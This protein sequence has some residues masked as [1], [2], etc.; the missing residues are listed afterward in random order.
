MERLPSEVEMIAAFQLQP[1]KCYLLRL[2][3]YMDATAIGQIREQLKEVGRWVS[4]TDPCRFILL[5]PIID[6]PVLPEAPPAWK[7]ELERNGD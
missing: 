2:T 3:K 5:P 1:G 7:R 6:S 4:E